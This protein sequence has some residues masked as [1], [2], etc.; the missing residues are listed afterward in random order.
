MSSKNIYTF[1]EQQR[2]KFKPTYLYIKQHSIT[3]LKYFG[4]TV[5]KNPIKYSGSGT[6]WL[7]HIKKYG[8]EHIDTIWY[9]LFTDI[10]ELFTVATA[11]SELFDIAES[12]FWANLKPETGLDGGDTFSSK[13]KEEMRIISEKLSKTNSGKNNPMYN[14][15][16]TYKMTEEE[17]CVWKSNIGLALKGVPKSEK[18]RNNLNLSSNFKPGKDHIMF[19]KDPWNKG[20]TGVQPKTLETKMKVSIPIIFSGIWYYSLNEVVKDTGLSAYFIKKELFGDGMISLKN[21]TSK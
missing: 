9:H 6:V 20:K 13:T 14:R 17:I 18:H 3:G 12:D 10:D 15:P 21:V 5:Q 19:G 4:K 2:S 8:I 1:T 11:L 7:R 16:C